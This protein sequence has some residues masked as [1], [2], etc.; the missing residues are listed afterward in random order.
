MINADVC[1]LIENDYDI[2][3]KAVVNVL[4]DA[5]DCGH[6][7]LP[8]IAQVMK[9]CDQWLNN[10][11]PVPSSRSLQWTSGG[12][13]GGST[14]S[15]RRLQG[16]SEIQFK[17]ITNVVCSV[18]AC[19]SDEDTAN[20]RR[21]SEVIMERVNNAIHGGSLT[22]ALESA[23]AIEG[24][25]LNCL[26]AWGGISSA[27]SNSDFLSDVGDAIPTTATFYPDWDGNSGTCINDDNAPR[28]QKLNPSEWIYDNLEACC[29]RYY[30]GYEKA[31]CMNK[32][33]SGLWAVDWINGRCSLDCEVRRGRLCGGVVGGTELFL[34][35]MSCCQSKLPWVSSEFCQ[36]DSLDVDCYDYD[37]TKKYYSSSKTC[38]KDCK[39]ADSNCG[40]IIH[41]PHV[42][43]YDSLETCCA[44]EFGWITRGLCVSRSNST[45][46]EKYWPDKVNSKCV[47]DSETA[48]KDLSVQLFVTAEE[49]CDTSIT[50]ERS[51]A[52]IATSTGE[53]AQGT[54]NY[55]VD[56]TSRKCVQDCEG[57]APCGGIAKKWDIL[58]TSARK[59]CGS[60]WN[61][62]DKC[63][64]Q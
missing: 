59:C 48:A 42:A 12:Q 61:D 45:V 25:V 21:M 35:P 26:V 5:A 40:G 57:G 18:A 36:A 53:I 3:V 24:F 31:K 34:D 1:N 52:C 11:R 7:S 9:I 46:T 23:L 55:F 63:D 51:V 27:S 28:Y 15:S 64:T 49:C 2:F 60:L 13:F 33:G 19:T 32:Q 62:P 39:T 54:S 17:I 37:G 22:S 38:V 16:T 43:L 44:A 8:C 14:P 20:T 29:D 47:K 4:Q 10:Y 41:E 30:S 58:Y 50:W 6:G 56:W